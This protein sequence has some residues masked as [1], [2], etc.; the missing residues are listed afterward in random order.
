MMQL[1]LW[2]SLFPIIKTVVESN[3]GDLPDSERFYWSS[4]CATDNKNFTYLVV[5]SL[6]NGIF[7]KQQGNNAHYIRPVR[8]FDLR[9]DWVEKQVASSNPLADTMLH[10]SPTETQ[11]YYYTVD[12]RG[13]T[14]LDSATVTVATQPVITAKNGT[15]VRNLGCNPTKIPTMTVDSFTV[16]DNT[17]PN[18]KVTLTKGD[19]V[20]NGCERS[21]TWTATY[22]N[23]CE[24]EA[25]PVQV[26]YHWVEFSVKADT[27]SNTYDG[28]PLSATYTYKPTGITPTLRYKIKNADDSWPGEYSTTLP[29]IT[30]AGTV[31]YMVEATASSCG[32]TVRDTATLT[33]TPK[34]VTVTAKSEEFTYDGTAH[35]NSGYDVVGLVG[36]DAI[37]AEVTGS[38]TFPSESPVTNTL[39]SYEFT[40]G[41]SDNYSVTKANGQLT[42]TNA[43][44]AITIT[45][46]S[47]AWTYDGDAH[48]NNTVTVT[49]GNLLDGD[50]LVAT[51][52]GSVTNVSE[53]ATG[54]NPIAAGYKIM[55]GEEDVTANYTITPV[56]GTLTINPKDVTV[57]VQDKA[58]VYT[59][60]AQSWPEYDVDGLIGSDA[61]TA[62]VTGS[63]TFPNE[64]PVTNEL[65]SYEFTTGTPGNYN[66][67]K[68]D[69]ELTM[70]NA[71]VLITITAASQSWTYDG[72]PHQNTTVTVTNGE[73]L[74]GDE[75]VATANGSVTNVADVAT[76]NNPIAAGYK[77]MHGEENVT[78]NYVITPVAGTLTIN[79]K[80]VTVS[81]EDKTVEYNG[82]EQSGNTLVNDGIG[83][84]PVF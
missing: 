46:A 69:G 29:S 8:D 49:S 35:S 80:E 25:N 7:K 75:L 74:T 22:Q 20:K 71:S 76:G 61:I 30:N 3:K 45:A 63:I 4:N 42:M 24:Q 38:I 66:V 59:G 27:L 73:L 81:V 52:T 34:L 54:N 70:S 51:A 5:S 36:N 56:A 12:Y 37:S 43:S 78:A 82:S 9:V 44:V 67:T 32:C 14:I 60:E 21:L 13:W 55:H 41:S 77:I 84:I 17:N 28:E 62:V 15:D 10:V 64:S 31:T 26:T 50:E 47:Q 16:V 6:P 1:R 18:V 57:K 19:T 33:I 23:M 53:T 48:S 79:P 65:T 83:L 58:F 40:A 68:A 72:T 11:K 2:N 39:T